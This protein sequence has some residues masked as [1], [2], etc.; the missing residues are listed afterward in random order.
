[1]EIEQFTVDDFFYCILVRTRPI[2]LAF[3]P[4][5]F[6]RHVTSLQIN[7]NLLLNFKNASHEHWPRVRTYTHTH[8]EYAHAKNMCL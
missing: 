1:M 2:V 3:V 4:F 8:T 7:E 5:F 6:S